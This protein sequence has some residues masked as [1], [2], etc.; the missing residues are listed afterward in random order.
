MHT[1][2]RNIYHKINFFKLF[3]YSEFILNIFFVI[4]SLIYNVSNHFFGFLCLSKCIFGIY[5]ESLPLC[6]INA[7]NKLMTMIK[8]CFLRFTNKLI[9]IFFIFISSVPGFSK[10]YYISNAGNDSNSGLSETTPW[11]TISKVNFFTFLPGDQILFKRGDSFYGSLTISNSGSPGNPITISAYGTGE[12]PVITGFT[13]VSEWTSLG[14]NIWESANAVSALSTCN[15]VVIDGVNTAM[16][17]WPNNINLTYESSNTNISISDNQLGT[18]I[19]WTGAEV[20]VYKNGYTLDRCLI[21]NHT[22]NILKYSS[23]G[24]TRNATAGND[25]F[26]QNDLRTLDQYG[27]WYFN[28]KTGKILIYFGGSDPKIVKTKIST[29]D[30]LLNNG[31]GADYIIIDGIDLEGSNNSSIKFNSGTDHCTFQ[32][33]HI[34]FS[35]YDA[36]TLSGTY[37]TIDHCTITNCNGGIVCNGSNATITNNSLE[38]IGV[39]AGQT[40]KIVT[41]IGMT[42]NGNNPLVQ[43]NSIDKT[44][45]MGIYLTPSAATGTIVNNFINYPGQIVTD[46]GGIYMGHDHPNTLINGN[47]ILNSGGNGIY[48]D[49]YCNGVTINMNTIE[50][51]EGDGIKLHKS[52]KNIVQNNLSFNNTYGISFENHISNENN[53]FGNII[54]ENEIIAKGSRQTILLIFN[55]FKSANVGIL[56]NNSYLSLDN[57]KVYKTFIAGIQ[58]EMNRI[59]EWQYFTGQDI[60]SK[61]SQFSTID[62]MSIIFKYN[63]TKNL[64]T[65]N[66]DQP[67]VDIKGKR[68]YGE[69]VLQPFTSVVLIRDTASVKFVTEHKSICEGASYNN[70]TKTGKYEQKLVSE[71]DEYI[72]KTTFLTVNPSYSISEEIEISEGETYNG[73][74]KTGVYNRNLSSVSGCDSIVRTNL[75]IKSS[76]TKQG[77][78][79]NPQ[80]FSPVEQANPT[81]NYMNISI[82]SISL[83]QY[84][85]VPGDEVAVFN[86]TTCVGTFLLSKPVVEQDASSYLSI[87]L[88]EGQNSNSGF[89]SGD[90]LIFKIWDSQNAIELTVPVA[91]YLISV[92]NTAVN[93]KFQPG[94]IVKVKFAQQSLTSTR[95]IAA[96]NVMNVFSNPNNGEFSVF[97]SKRSDPQSRITVFDVSGRFVTSRNISA[98]LEN[99]DLSDQPPG[100]YLVNAILGSE[101]YTQKIIIN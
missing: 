24:T 57:S 31:S 65:I 88:F 91:L 43:Y 4:N 48:L 2:V 83:G 3:F 62:E 90:S 5:F 67:M 81:G 98:D 17:R 80:H 87:N 29:I 53:L 60:T 34:S 6:R 85:P 82:V 76:S 14:G 25:Y 59:E 26:I 99:F 58:L 54:S 68:Y 28:Q 18:A 70:W 74:S 72:L 42:I 36:F 1:T 63:S 55:K 47:I 49:E 40:N 66:V 21:T 71:N 101:K 9:L 39:I 44:G 13:T 37:P 35:G 97:F 8:Y 92:E 23:L 95:T 100:L 78:I 52:Y 96:K 27:E 93:G 16:G 86:G 15:M 38:N 41:A 22:G 30:N 11:Q 94:S 84:L 45:Y 12:N 56:N 20:V 61:K 46:A 75:I 79:I 32:N 50:G 77:L 10:N 7:L 19:N 69:F 51:S 89:T 33:C 73:W 64:K